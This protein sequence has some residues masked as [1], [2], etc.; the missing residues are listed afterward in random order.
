MS[1]VIINATEAG[2]HNLSPLGTALAPNVFLKTSVNHDGLINSCATGW[3]T[4]ESGMYE[5]FGV[6]V[7][8]EQIDI[9]DP[10]LGTQVELVVTQLEYYRIEDGIRIVTGVMIL[11]EPLV[12]TATYDQLN[13]DEYGWRADLGDTLENAVQAE[14]FVF[15]GG[16]GNDVFAAHTDIGP[17]FGRNVINGRGGDDHLTGSLGDDTIRGGSG[18]DVIYDDGGA[19]KLRGGRGDDV[20]ELGNGSDDSVAWGGRGHDLLISGNGDDKLIGNSGRDTLIGGRGDDVLRGGNGRDNL[21]GGR[22]DDLIIGGHGA[23]ILTGGDGADQFI[24]KANHRGKDVITDFADG[25]DLIV[26]RGLA[27]MNDLHM[28]QIGDDVVIGWGASDKI[29]VE[30]IEIANLTADDFLFM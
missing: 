5:D 9:V 13:V 17:V 16:S 18:N 4:R 12:I 22:G 28:R 7:I 8:A 27:G 1:R 25:E 24:F 26:M 19:N 6:S 10:K 20:I 29:I 14:G 11:P 23:D 2:F 21:D 15:N 3:E 30:D